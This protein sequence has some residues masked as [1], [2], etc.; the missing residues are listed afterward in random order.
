MLWSVVCGE[1]RVPWQTLK[2][3]FVKQLVLFTVLNTIT[4]G[5]QLYRRWHWSEADRDAIY[6]AVSLVYSML[7]LGAYSMYKNNAGAFS[8]FVTYGC[9][10][11]SARVAYLVLTVIMVALSCQQQQRL[12]QGCQAAVPVL[13][14]LNDDSCTRSDLDK[15]NSFANKSC[16]AWGT[17][18]CSSMPLTYTTLGFAPYRILFLLID[19]LTAYFPLYTAYLLLLRLENKFFISAMKNDTESQGTP[20]QLKRVV[21]RKSH[22]EGDRLLE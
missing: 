14:C 8:A 9:F 17:N 10:I 5:V 12:F 18:E 22:G 20:G 1:N 11:S 4:A 13:G 21:N 7:P 16:D 6:V 19:V 3:L 2:D 15:Y